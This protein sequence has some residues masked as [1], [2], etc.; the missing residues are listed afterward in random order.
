M[1]LLTTTILSS[2]FFTVSYVYFDLLLEVTTA[3]FKPQVTCDFHQSVSKTI[4][5]SPLALLEIRQKGTGLL[6]DFIR[7]LITRNF[8]MTR[9]ADEFN[10]RN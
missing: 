10:H 6:N 3:T 1:A 4:W 9:Q 5:I 2:L 7:N 8:I